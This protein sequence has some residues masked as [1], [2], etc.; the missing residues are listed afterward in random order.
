MKYQLRNLRHSFTFGAV[1]V[2]RRTYQRLLDEAAKG[3]ANFYFWPADLAVPGGVA[4]Q[5]ISQTS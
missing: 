5:S 4:L 2:T 3:S 1:E